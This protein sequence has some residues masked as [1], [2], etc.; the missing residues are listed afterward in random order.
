[1]KN[2]FVVFALFAFLAA[3]SDHVLAQQPALEIK[4]GFSDKQ[5]LEIQ[6]G[7]KLWADQYSSSREIVVEPHLINEVSKSSDGSTLT[8][9]EI[10]T[11]G[12]IRINPG[13]ID[14]FN[15]AR[16]LVLH[17]MTHA[18][19]QTSP[20]LLAKP[21]RFADYEIIGYHGASLVVLLKNGKQT[22]WRKLEE[23]LCDRNAYYAVK[24]GKSPIKYVVTDPRYYRAG[25]QAI[26]DFPETVDVMPLIRSNDFPGLIA[27]IVKKKRDEVTPDDILRVMD[28][29]GALWKT[30]IG[31]DKQ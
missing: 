4:P 13:L 7:F 6:E 21:L 5:I 17:S 11:P 28:R 8:T 27:I 3:V 15:T 29:Y 23:G 9:L 12:L 24:S 20:T 30:P 14:E 25:Q 16:D 22:A 19:Q 31:P 1:M 18:D 2:R 26:R 10:T